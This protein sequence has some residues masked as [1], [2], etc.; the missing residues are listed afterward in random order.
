M[1]VGGAGIFQQA[2]IRKP[3]EAYA[4]SDAGGVQHRAGIEPANVPW[5]IYVA[6]SNGDSI[7][8]AMYQALHTTID[9]AGLY[10]VLEMKEVHESWRDALKYNAQ[11]NAEIE[12]RRA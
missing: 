10:D 4:S 3:L 6:C 5:E 12:A 11:L 8:G 7:D 1:Y 9:L 2:L